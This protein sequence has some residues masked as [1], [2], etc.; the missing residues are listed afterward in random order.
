MELRAYQQD[1]LDSVWSY[2]GNGGGNPLVDMATGL[3]K[4]VVIGKLTRDICETYPEM[5]ILA[6]VHVKELVEQNFL[7]LHKLWPQAPAGIYSAGLGRRDRHHRIT[8][9][10][11]Q[12]LYR[13]DGYSLGP[14][15]LVIVDEA[16]LIP[17]SGDGMYRTLID[18]LRDRV[19]DMRVC[20]FT[21]TPF[22]MG[23]GRLD[24]G[25][26]RLFDEIVYTYGVGD[27]I[28]DKWL[29]PLVSKGGRTE[30]DV[31]AVAK[32]GG[33][34]IP[35]ALEAAADQDEITKAAI[36]ECLTLGADRRSWLVF[37]AGVKHAYR[38]RDALRLAGISAE[39]ITGETP[40]AERARHIADFKAG[41]IR[42]LT[43]ANVLTTGFDAPGVDLL[44]MLRPTLSTG[45]Y[46]QMVGRGTRLAPGKANCLVL[47]F[48]GNVRRHGPVDM[49]EPPGR[50]GGKGVAA[51]T[52]DEVRAKICPDCQSYVALN[53][54][55]CSYCGH[56]WPFVVTPKH[57]REA[58]TIPILSGAPKLSMIDDVPVTSWSAR[59][60]EKLGSPDSVCVTYFAGLQSY[61]EWMAFE[62]LG[63]PRQKASKF[64]FQ[65]G[66]LDPVPQTVSEA[67]NRWDELD[68]PALIQTRKNGKWFDI[69]GRKFGPKGSTPP[70]IV[71]RSEPRVEALACLD[72]EIPF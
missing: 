51:A 50:K 2:W 30:I 41:R 10:T 47:D 55:T 23:E 11:V 18:K 61:R 27:G 62:H 19:P 65:H 22:R 64:W 56:E 58:D 36:G 46:I 40:S 60:H 71:E 45:L 67:L 17:G 69:V 57:E 15:H 37:C 35:G 44:V 52:V 68:Q 34:F 25:E 42:A 43:N 63:F 33:E 3:G 70:A 6:L 8:F 49:I 24:Q 9:G 72:D 31:S 16:H 13:Q 29:S 12:S 53:T 39:T 59:R 4:S 20:G 66:G 32:R 21:A 54:R 48:A 28:A 38:V 7:A 26:D 1:A 14:R 5:R